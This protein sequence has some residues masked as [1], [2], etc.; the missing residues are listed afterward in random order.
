MATRELE[1]PT[2][3]PIN[4]FSVSSIN[5]Y[6]K[7]PLKWKRR[8][9]D[10]EYEPPSGARILGSAVGAAE[11][12]AYQV[13]I[14]EPQRPSIDD[15]L[16]L[17]A[18]EFDERAEKEEVDWGGDKPGEL[19]DT[20]VLAVKAYEDTIVP[21]IVPVSVE[22]EFQLQF[23]GVEWGLKGYLDLESTD[24]TVDD[25]K[26]RK[27]RLQRKDADGD[28]QPTTYLLARRSEGKP[29]KRFRF[30]AMVKTKTPYAE[31]VPTVR[32]D[33]QL[34]AFVDRV[35]QI[36]AEIQW[37]LEHDNWAG[38][39]PNAWWCSERMCGYWHNCP[40]GGAR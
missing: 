37:R 13:Q 3:L 39:V 10:G 20:G 22:R 14:E 31:L 16:D 34:D 17:Y 18:A 33:R 32:T 5:A 40:M 1:I 19:K 9:I 25:L 2:R 8:Y 35:Y 36:A 6:L 24:D 38:A 28:M 30:H 11:G 26:V 21:S 7:C 23:D 4:N 15:V 27:G 12:H 29:A